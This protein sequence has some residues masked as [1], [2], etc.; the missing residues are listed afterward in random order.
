MRSATASA[1]V[2]SSL[3]LRNA[4]LV[5]SPPAVTLY[6]GDVLAGVASGA[7]E[8]NDYAVVDGPPFPVCEREIG[9]LAGS[10]ELSRDFLR[11]I[12]GLLS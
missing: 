5:N 9:C 3:P 12:R 11:G 4:L 6:F 1:S 2:R 8:I 7:L 10:R